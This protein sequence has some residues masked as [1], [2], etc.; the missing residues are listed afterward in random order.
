MAVPLAIFDLDGTLVDQRSAAHE[1]AHAFAQKWSVA[2]AT[3]SIASA[4]IERRDKGV[5]FE[6]ITSRFALPVAP[7]DVWA[8]YHSIADAVGRILE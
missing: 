5:V 3:E 8:D 7:A 4:L 1:W 2:D 6:E